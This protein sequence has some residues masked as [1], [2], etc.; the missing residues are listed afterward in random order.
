MNGQISVI[1]NGQTPANV[2]VINNSAP[3]YDGKWQ[4]LTRFSNSYFF[5]SNCV[6]MVSPPV[7][8]RSFL[9]VQN[10]I[11]I[12]WN[13]WYVATSLRPPETNYPAAGIFWLIFILGIAEIVSILCGFV[14]SCFARSELNALERDGRGGPTGK[15]KLCLIFYLIG[16]WIAV[17]FFVI[18][19][20]FAAYFI[21]ALRN[22]SANSNSTEA[23]VAG[24]IA[25]VL[26]LFAILLLPVALV[27]I[28]Q[29]VQCC[30]QR[31]AL[32]HCGPLQPGEKA[33]AEPKLQVFSQAQHG[34]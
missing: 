26:L 24:V 23:A 2:V 28:A 8:I 16:L 9:C 19:W 5:C 29:L 14:L 3:N 15:T 1:S 13:G 10:V 4:G 18:F 27:Y 33:Q 21:L 30:K 20:I 31:D 25:F 32:S 12:I 6:N 22:A 17:G 7:A 11:D 34:G